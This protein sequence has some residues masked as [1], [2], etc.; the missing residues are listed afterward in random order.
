M[1][2]DI[3]LLAD[4]R[5]QS[6]KSKA[7]L[8][9]DAGVSIGSMLGYFKGKTLVPTFRREAIAKALGVSVDWPE[10]ERQLAQISATMPHKAV[11]PA[12]PKKTPEKPSAANSEPQGDSG[13]FWDDLFQVDS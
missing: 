6:R 5:K 13:S 8:A 4:L 3:Q 12:I 9:N 2:Q 7:R 11:S 10:Y 1:A